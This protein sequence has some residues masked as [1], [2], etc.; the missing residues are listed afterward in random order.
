M[1]LNK[2][3]KILV[4][5]IYNY[6]NKQEQQLFVFVFFDDNFGN[7]IPDI[8]IFDDYEKALNYLRNKVYRVFKNNDAI[9]SEIEEVLDSIK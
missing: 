3:E 5:I 1:R 2:E 9:L 6:E 4:N 8:L 7:N